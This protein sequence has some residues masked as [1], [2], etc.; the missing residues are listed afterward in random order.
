MTILKVKFSMSKM[1]QQ[2]SIKIGDKPDSPPSLMRLFISILYRNCCHLK[3]KGS[4]FLHSNV[5]SIVQQ[6]ISSKN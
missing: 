2:Q 4:I 3:G 5:H 1:T 6:L